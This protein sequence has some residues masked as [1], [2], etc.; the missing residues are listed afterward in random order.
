MTPVKEAS[1]MSNTTLTAT[2]RRIYEY[3]C[4]EIETTGYPPAIRNIG[5]AFGISSPNGVM[6]HLKA[7]EKKGYIKRKDNQARAIQV[8]GIRVGGATIP[9]LGLVA[10][11]TAIEAVPSDD[12]I[13]LAEMFN[14]EEHYALRVR[15]QSMIEDHIDD[16]DVVI[17]R[18]QDTAAN[19][20]RVVA[21]IDKEVTLKKFFKKRNQI[22]LEPANGSMATIV[23]DSSKDISILGVLV[24]VLRKV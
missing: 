5:D 6:C 17:I 22:H 7:L 3:I 14:G 10:A 19:G 20:E 23:V 21:M 4:R 2:Q 8:E 12:R 18:R 24:G 15:G 13:N 9:L 16:G 11:G 1:V